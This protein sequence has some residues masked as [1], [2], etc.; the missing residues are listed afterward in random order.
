MELL[1]VA[2]AVAR[3]KHIDKE[4]V[5]EALE[6]AIQ[7]AARSKYGYDKDIRAS[8]DRIQGVVILK[9]YQTVVEAMPE[10]ELNEEGEDISETTGLIT[11]ANAKRIKPDVA[12]GDEL[13][14]DLPP[15]LR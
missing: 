7:K 1:H 9:N 2:E 8:I 6:E 5:I 12:V 14:D 13:I 10:P 15:L 3:E 11:L 4:I